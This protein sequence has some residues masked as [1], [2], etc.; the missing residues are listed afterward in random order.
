MRRP[1]LTGRAAILAVVVCAIVMSLAYPVR[2]YIAQRRQI[3]ELEEQ[4]ARALEDLRRLTELNRRLSD[5]DY[6]RQQARARLHYC[7]VGERCYVVRDDTADADRP[8]AAAATRSGPKVPW[9]QALWESAEA[10]DKGT[11][12][13]ADQRGRAE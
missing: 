5:P 11:G 1:Q 4:Q 2:E 10:A 8:A 9:Y 6:I 3:A 7:G 12:R 13:R